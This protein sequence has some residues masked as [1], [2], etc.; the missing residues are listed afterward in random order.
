MLRRLRLAPVVL[1]LTA[2]CAGHAVGRGPEP[3]DTAPP[4][5]QREMRGLWVAT[6]ANIDWPS[7][8]GLSVQQQQSELTGILERAAGIGINTIV[9][10]VRPAADA[11]YE[12]SL[13]PWA[14]WLT[15][16]Q[17][18][19]P[20]YDPLAF[21]VAASHARGLQLHAWINPFRAGNTADTLKL[22]PT[23]VFNVRR[24][25]VRV[26]G[27]NLWMDPGDPAARDRARDVI[28]DIVYR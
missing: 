8:P 26:Y 24:D 1:G 27:A 7:R 10:Q 15:G 6:V 9:L 3:A 28:A 20:G 19:G 17:G 21:A 11:L 5:I 13:E 14:A 23:H 2:A 16:T 22:A 4:A 18:V 12:S 25:L